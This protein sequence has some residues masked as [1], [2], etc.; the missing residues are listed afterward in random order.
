LTYTFTRLARCWL[1]VTRCGRVG[2]DPRRNRCFHSSIDK[3]VRPRERTL[4]VGSLSIRSAGGSRPPVD[5]GDVER[6][7]V[8]VC[9]LTDGRH[10][11]ARTGQ[12]TGGQKDLF[13]M[14][15]SQRSRGRPRRPPRESRITVSPPFGPVN[16]TSRGTGGSTGR[17][18]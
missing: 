6:H 14:G 15:L 3:V 11:V 2:I 16:T 8:S 12:E 9:P 5:A 4:A 7:G 17:A 13:T 1:A 18:E 10:T